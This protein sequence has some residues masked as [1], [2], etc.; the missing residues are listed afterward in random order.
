[1][2]SC[3]FGWNWAHNFGIALA[4][5]LDSLKLVLQVTFCTPPGPQFGGDS[6]R[7]Q[8][9]RYVLSTLISFSKAF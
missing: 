6:I 3:R 5:K 8:P 7:I 1:M 4:R 9:I 2:L